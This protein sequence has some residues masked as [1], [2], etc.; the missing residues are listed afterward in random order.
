[1]RLAQNGAQ[2]LGQCMLFVWKLYIFKHCI[3]MRTYVPAHHDIR[4]RIP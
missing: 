3:E 1:M 4:T 2:I